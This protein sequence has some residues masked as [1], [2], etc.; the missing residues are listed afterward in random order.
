M[1]LC[2]NL[3]CFTNIFDVSLLSLIREKTDLT[4][5]STH[6]VIKIRH[7]RTKMLRD[8]DSLKTRLLFIKW[9]MI[10]VLHNVIV[11]T[12]IPF[13][14]ISRKENCTET[15]LIKYETRH[16]TFFLIQ[17]NA[18]YT[19]SFFN[20]GIPQL[21]TQGQRTHLTKIHAIHHKNVAAFTER[22]C[23]V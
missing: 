9:P 17:W 2:G 10:I 4:N 22:W 13:L 8:S 12:E 18:Y 19:L 16:Y 3:I 21:K 5:N 7:H 14:L 6:V 15:I 11:F 20:H 23:N 1:W